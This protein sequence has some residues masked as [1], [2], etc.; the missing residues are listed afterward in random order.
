METQSEEDPEPESRILEQAS[1]H[2]NDL[3]KEIADELDI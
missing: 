2:E 1:N 3:D